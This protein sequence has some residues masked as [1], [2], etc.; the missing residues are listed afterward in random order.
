[1]F[2]SGSSGSKIVLGGTFVLGISYKERGVAFNPVLV[3][4]AMLGIQHWALQAVRH[5]SLYYFIYLFC[6]KMLSFYVT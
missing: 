4:K 6:L 2:I 3:G 1:M 5:L